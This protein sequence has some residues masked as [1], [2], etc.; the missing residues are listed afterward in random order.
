V[1]NSTGQE[2]SQ[3]SIE[4]LLGLE[5]SNEGASST[6]NSETP[7]TST[8]VLVNNIPL[9]EYFPLTVDRERVIR[10]LKLVGALGAYNVFCLVRGGGTSGQSGAIAHGIAKGVAV[11]AP[12]MHD[13]LKAGSCHLVVA[14]TLFSSTIFNFQPNYSDVTLVWWN[15]KSQAWPRHAKLFVFVILHSVTCSLCFVIVCMGQTV[16]L[17][18]TYFYVNR[19]SLNTLIISFSRLTGGS[20]S[21]KKNICKV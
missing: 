11:H 8:T 14:A 17:T 20:I 4:T 21:W 3:E 16:V 12:D 1:E 15:A 7:V 18:F 9:A 13:V 19:A 6:A 2:V 5:Q 10:P